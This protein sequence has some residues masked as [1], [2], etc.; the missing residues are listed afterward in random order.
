MPI[1]TI[2]IIGPGSMG[3]LWAAY[4]SKSGVDVEVFTRQHKANQSM[5]LRTADES[6]DFEA[7]YSTF[8]YWRTADCILICVKAIHIEAV[9][10]QL[11]SLSNAHPPIILMMNGLG[12]VEIAKRYLPDNQVYQA[13]T[14][15][16]AQLVHLRESRSLS[17]V[18]TIEHTGTGITLIG[19]LHHSPAMAGNRI[20][21]ASIIDA[22]NSALPNCQWNKEHLSSLWLK[23]LVNAIINPLTA[24]H[25]VANGEIVSDSQ[26]NNK[27]KQLAKELAPIIQVF[28]PLLSWQSLFEKVETIA[29]Q[30]YTNSSSMRQDLK[31]GKKTEI[32]FISGYILNQAKILGISLPKQE[33]IVKCIKTLEFEYYNSVTK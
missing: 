14:T 10:Q 33:Q 13:S 22:L 30:T 16:G 21:I 17:I 4:L 26:L 24:Y 7:V 18:Q 3:H 31:A 32:D 27:A 5:L 12:L 20:G 9:C 19:D 28:V 1:K 29:N 2:N 11:K 25:D 23:L 8:D 15:H 6:F